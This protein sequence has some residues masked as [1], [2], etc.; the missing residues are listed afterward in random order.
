M[1]L[2]LLKRKFDGF[3]HW[4]VTM[5]LVVAADNENDAWEVNGAINFNLDRQEVEI[6]ELGGA[7]PN[8]E[9]GIILED[10]KS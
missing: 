2:F 10:Y 1:K 8:I 6:T 5:G 9:R 3:D 7:N 4:D